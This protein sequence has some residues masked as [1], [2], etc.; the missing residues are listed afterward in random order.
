VTEPWIRLGPLHPH[1]VL[2]ALAYALGFALYRHERRRRGDPIDEDLRWTVIVAAAVGAVLGSKL[3]ALLQAPSQLGQAFRS[4][5]A[6]L[7]SGK[8]IVGGLLGGWLA[9]EAAKRRAGES[10]RT[11]DLF[12][13]PLA[14]GIAVGRVGCFLT[15]L[16]DRTYGTATTLPW[17]LDLGDGVPRHPAPLY[18][19]LFLLALAAVLARSRGRLGSGGEFRLFLAAYLA[20]RVL[21]DALKPGERSL[22]LTAIQWAAILGLLALA[23]GLHAGRRR[24]TENLPHG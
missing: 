10:R 24:A 2:E 5:L 21:A 6:F 9:V 8:T 22:G 16:P 19:I 14:V 20:F 4:P 1:L 18:E 7:A 17:G 3:L 11:G 15:G 12:A 13:L 23:W